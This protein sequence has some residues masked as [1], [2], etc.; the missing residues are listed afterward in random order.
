VVRGS[1]DASEDD[2]FA[3]LKETQ[4]GWVGDEATDLGAAP[5]RVTRNGR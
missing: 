2:P 4:C 1:Q 5:E 3:V